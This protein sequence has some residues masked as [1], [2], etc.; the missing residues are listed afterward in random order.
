MELA[1]GGTVPI[2]T[3]SAA[4]APTTA[5]AATTATT[6]TTTATTTTTTTTTS[7]T[8][9]PDTSPAAAVL[10]SIERSE[11]MTE[12]ERDVMLRDA[13]MEMQLERLTSGV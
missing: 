8:P 11:S 1:P 9:T 2:S 3:T 7:T 6:T 10:G 4:A 5:T 13:V 12:D